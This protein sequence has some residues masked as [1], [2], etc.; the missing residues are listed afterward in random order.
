MKCETEMVKIQVVEIVVERILAANVI[1]AGGDDLVYK[2]LT[3]PVRFPKT[4]LA[5]TQ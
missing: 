1:N 5:K 4:R 3:S 2:T